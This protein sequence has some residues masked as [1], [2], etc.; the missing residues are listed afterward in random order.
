MPNVRIPRPLALAAV[1]LAA[2]AGATS[3]AAAAEPVAALPPP[4]H[5]G[6]TVATV[7]ARTLQEWPA[8]TFLESIAI[9]ADGTMYIADHE[10]G[11][12]VR[13]PRDGAAAKFAK[14]PGSLTGLEVAAD[15][16]LL[17]TGR[18]KGG[19]ETVYRVA[20]DGAVEPLVAIADAKFLN[21]L[22]R[23]GAG[24]VLVADSATGTVWHVDLTTRA[25]S[26]WLSHDLL[27]RRAPDS[28][29]P[30]ANGVKV[31]GDH[32]YVS[33]SDRAL[34]VRVP[35]LPG[36]TAG[37]PE[38]LAR[39]VV[40][41]DFAF[42]VDGNLYGA[43]HPLNT[44]VRIDPKG[45]VTTIAGPDAGVV[46]STAVAFG[47]TPADERTLYVV[48]D[49]GV[50]APPGGKLQPAKLVALEVG[51]PGYPKYR[52]RTFA[53][54]QVPRDQVFMVT[55]T[56]AKDA[57]AEV[58][59]KAGQAYLEYIERNVGRIALGGQVF[60]DPAGQPVARVYFVAARDAADARAFVEGS[61]YF[62]AGL[63]SD[64]QVRPFA[65][66]LGD[67]PGG[68]TWPPRTVAPAK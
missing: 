21:G 44:V 4:K 51:A 50:F 52:R 56:T 62:K 3:P 38:V 45:T 5:V 16:G 55:A 57:A 49:G 59:R 8:G 68:V 37:A 23:F 2:A 12:V 10:S 27:G 36:G 25:A 39:D 58:R 18:V 30:A 47:V 60:E 65:V 67:Y 61:P 48:G 42:D 53:V 35:I 7:P 43:T 54:R 66:M 34:V 11:E 63:Y 22:T 29:F 6:G 41:D 1:S 64:V 13:R 26:A 17:A 28:R 9:A 14:L 19:A 20:A 15:G 31:F 32:A 24:A 40:V 33:N 46:G